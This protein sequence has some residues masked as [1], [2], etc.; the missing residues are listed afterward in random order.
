LY[1][2]VINNIK[3]D[4]AAQ[5][6]LELQNR[7]QMLKQIKNAILQGLTSYANVRTKKQI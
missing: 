6:Q 5:K 7:E 1:E 2:E 4:E 3:P